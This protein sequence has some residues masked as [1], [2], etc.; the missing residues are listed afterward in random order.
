MPAPDR[1]DR[2]AAS[3][4]TMAGDGSSDARSLRPVQAA[5]AGHR[6][7]RDPGVDGVAR[8][9]GR[10]GRRR[11]RPLP[12]LQAAQARPP[13][14][15]GPAAAGPDPLHQ[16]HLAGAG[17]VLPRRRGHGAADPPHDPLE[18]AGDGAARQYPLRGIGGH[19]STYAS[20]PAC[21]RSASTTSSAGPTTA[22]PATRSTSRA[23]PRP[24]STRGRSWRGACRRSSSTTSGARRCGP[25]ACRRTR[26][27]G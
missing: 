22:A 8:R 24:A 2:A 6:P 12:D 11:P 17:A 21:T 25:A 13:A 7:G 5:A 27:R 19:L 14:E 26:I 9:R 4:C 10:A 18:R 20:P 1:H 23:T 3:V 16:H 15:C